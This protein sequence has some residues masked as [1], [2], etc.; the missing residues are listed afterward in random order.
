MLCRHLL[1]LVLM[2]LV[3]VLLMLIFDR[4]FLLVH[5]MARR[6]IIGTCWQS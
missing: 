1:V 3:L 6:G 4:R 5:G 2:L